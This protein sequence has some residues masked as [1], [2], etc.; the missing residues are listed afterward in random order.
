LADQI[1]YFIETG[2]VPRNRGGAPSHDEHGHVSVPRDG[3]DPQPSGSRREQTDDTH[4]PAFETHSLTRDRDEDRGEPSSAAAP[5]GWEV[6]E[7]LTTI[8]P[9]PGPELHPTDPVVGLW[10]RIDRWRLT[11]LRARSSLA[12]S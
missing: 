1:A 5:R 2:H 8:H 3:R 11:S 10:G 7:P 4:T 6:S 12:S 9:G